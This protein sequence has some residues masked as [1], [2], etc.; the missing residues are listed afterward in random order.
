MAALAQ[1]EESWTVN[2]EVPTPGDGQT[3]V[4]IGKTNNA[5]P[6]DGNSIN[7]W[8]DTAFSGYVTQR[9]EGLQPGSYVLS[10]ALYGG[11]SN[12]GTVAQLIACTSVKPDYAQNFSFEGWQKASQRQLAIDVGQ[13]GTATV[14]FRIDS[15]NGKEWFSKCFPFSFDR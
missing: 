10:A 15:K 9:I 2:S 12:D 14:G 13:D 11:D 8:N 7:F 5:L 6:A 3:G 1:G 4:W